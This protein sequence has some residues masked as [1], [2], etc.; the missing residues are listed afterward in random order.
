MFYKD[1]HN[2]KSDTI[3][4]EEKLICADSRKN[5]DEVSELLNFSEF[6]YRDTNAPGIVDNMIDESCLKR[7]EK[8]V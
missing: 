1:Y 4:K 8:H 3:T 7:Q 6:Y 2:Y 5:F